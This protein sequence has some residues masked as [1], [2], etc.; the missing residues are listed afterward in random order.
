MRRRKQILLFFCILCCFGAVYVPLL[1][2]GYAI[3]ISTEAVWNGQRNLGQSAVL[4]AVSCGIIW[5]SPILVWYLARKVRRHRVD[6]GSAN[7]QT[8]S[9]RR[10]LGSW[11]QGAPV[12]P[13]GPRRD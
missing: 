12:R 6:H 4:V 8:Q 10:G 9:K 1:V 3:A 11:V 7:G 13:D 2:A 5:T